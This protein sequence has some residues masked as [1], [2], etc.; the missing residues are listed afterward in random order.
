[1]TLKL[2]QLPVGIYRLKNWD[3]VP[4]VYQVNR[5]NEGLFDVFIQRSISREWDNAMIIELHWQEII[6]CFDNLVNLFPNR[7]Q[8]QKRWNILLHHLLLT[9]TFFALQCIFKMLIW[10]W[11]NIW[12]L[13][14]SGDWMYN[15]VSVYI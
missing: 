9:H 13:R 7:G 4:I 5:S 3:F 1:M 10:I 15:V 8:T 2:R 6:N 11:S 14:I 12:V